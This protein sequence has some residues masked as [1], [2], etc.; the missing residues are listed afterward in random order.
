M[1]QVAELKET[2]N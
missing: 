1:L 2:F